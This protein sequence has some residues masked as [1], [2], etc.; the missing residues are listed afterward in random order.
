[1]QKAII[2]KDT[3]TIRRLTIDD[4]PDILSD[5]EVIVLEN[6]IDL[7]GGFWKLNNMNEKVEATEKESIDSGVNEEKV[8]EAK[9][10]K[11]EDLKRKIEKLSKGINDKDLQDY[12]TLLNELK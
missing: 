11:N 7:S 9:L 6:S 4:N 5:E 3:R 12:F 8:Q 10:L 1:M 2:H